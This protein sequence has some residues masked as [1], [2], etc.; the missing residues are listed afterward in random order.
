MQTEDV[1]RKKVKPQKLAQRG[2]L[3]VL[4]ILALA[5]IITIV[6]ELNV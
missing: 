2:K 5:L 6:Q 4:V 1:A 3:I